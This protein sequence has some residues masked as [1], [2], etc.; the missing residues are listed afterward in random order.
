MACVQQYLSDVGP[1]LKLIDKGFLDP[2][3]CE[4]L[5][6]FDG[7]IFG[8][9]CGAASVLLGMERTCR[10][11]T[12]VSPGNE[13]KINNTSCHLIDWSWIL[14]H[15]PPFSSKIFLYLE[16]HWC[17]VL[18]W[19]LLVVFQCRNSYLWTRNISHSS[20]IEFLDLLQSDELVKETFFPFVII[21]IND[22]IYFSFQGLCCREKL[23]LLLMDDTWLLDTN[24]FKVLLDRLWLE[25][26]D[27]CD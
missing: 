15:S 7:P 26:S 18:V 8:W 21:S 5:V 6:W 3:F 11:V 19:I 1:S 12:L 23:P 10:W 22:A 20:S 9:H 2:T 14:I 13:M 25:R 17:L 24:S 4:I 27:F 16:V